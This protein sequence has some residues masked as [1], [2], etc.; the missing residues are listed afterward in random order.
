VALHPHDELGAMEQIESLRRVKA[1]RESDGVERALSALRAD[2]AAGR[3]V[4]PA[5]MRA[6][7]SYASVGEMTKALVEVYGRF[8]EPTQ[9]WRMV[10]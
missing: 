10:A 6:V 5:L 8:K 3:N 1:E 7:K 9:L 2:A 4:M